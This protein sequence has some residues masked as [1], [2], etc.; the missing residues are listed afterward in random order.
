M[1]SLNNIIKNWIIPP[2]E[3]KILLKIKNKLFNNKKENENFIKQK[4]IDE[5]LFIKNDTIKN[6]HEG[7]RCFVLGAG[8]SIAHQDLKKLKNEYVIS[9]SN[10]FVH[11]D[12][13]EIKNKYHVLPGIMVSH[14]GFY[15][16]NKFVEWLK[17]MEEKTGNAEMFFHV[18]DKELL[19]K[20]GLFKNRIIYWNEYIAWNEEKE[21]TDIDLRRIPGIWSVSEYAITVALYLG[22]DKIYLIALITTGLTDLWSTFMIKKK[23]INF[24]RM[25]KL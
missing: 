2:A 24:N 10:T 7:K 9:V 23:S 19:E 25:K 11:P 15:D 3:L 8:S 6:I 1:T 21:L 12:Y 17:E 20:N 13:K 22:F 14:S 4:F 18:G 16:I 5:E